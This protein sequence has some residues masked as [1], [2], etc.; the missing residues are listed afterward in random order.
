[1]IR[2]S[3]TRICEKIM[4]QQKDKS[5]IRFNWVTI[6]VDI[7]DGPEPEGTRRSWQESQAPGSQ[8]RSQTPGG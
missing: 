8:T 2:K 3:G 7:R 5:V 4:L 6:L 1:M